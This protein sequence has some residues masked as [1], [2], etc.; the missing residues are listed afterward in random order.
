[1]FNW[2]FSR[3]LTVHNTSG[4]RV[5]VSTRVARL[6]PFQ[7][8]WGTYRALFFSLGA[9]LLYTDRPLSGGC[10]IDPFPF[11]LR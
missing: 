6:V 8:E 9:S 7:R 4:G 10:G 11:P 5:G 3:S 2:L 1:L